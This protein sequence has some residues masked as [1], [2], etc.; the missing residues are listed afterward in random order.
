[1]S[2]HVQFCPKLI[3]ADENKTRIF[4]EN[5]SVYQALE[6]HVCTKKQMDKSSLDNPNSYV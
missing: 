5:I 3:L 6:F 4:K 2:F 1:M